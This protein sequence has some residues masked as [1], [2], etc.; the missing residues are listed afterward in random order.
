MLCLYPTRLCLDYLGKMT[1]CIPNEF[2]VS[3]RRPGG[4]TDER[5]HTM[6]RA[7]ADNKAVT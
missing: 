2:R 5:R 7:P 3:A 6:R 4:E 1:G